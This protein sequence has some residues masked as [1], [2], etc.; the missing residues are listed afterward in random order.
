MNIEN[1]ND[2]LTLIISG[3]NTKSSK[4]FFAYTNKDNI[5]HSDTFDQFIIDENLDIE[6]DWYFDTALAITKMGYM[7][8]CN[9][10]ITNEILLFCPSINQI[11]KTQKIFLSL[12][13]TKF[14]N[15]ENINILLYD[16]KSDDFIEKC[17]NNFDT[18]QLITNDQKVFIKKQ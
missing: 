7:T 14:N 8:I 2:L 12:L 3:N 6:N 16:E 10:P 9:I 15:F 17:I 5:T 13:E 1:I 11:S 4:N 18:D